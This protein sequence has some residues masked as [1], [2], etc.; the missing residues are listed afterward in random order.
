MI[1]ILVRF[2]K[3]RL[4][5]IST[6][7]HPTLQVGADGEFPNRFLYRGEA[8]VSIQLRDAAQINWAAAR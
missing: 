8:N 5:W 1:V 4:E 2:M 3:R 6:R 7:Q